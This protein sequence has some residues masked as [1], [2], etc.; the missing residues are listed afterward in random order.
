MAPEKDTPVNIENLV[1]KLIYALLTEKPAT[2]SRMQEIVSRLIPQ[3]VH[4]L[5]REGKIELKMVGNKKNDIKARL[6]IK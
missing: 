1:E 5:D 6:H 2:A 4:K 3:A